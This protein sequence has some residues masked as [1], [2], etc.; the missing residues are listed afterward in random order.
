MHCS[1]VNLYL[2]LRGISLGKQALHERAAT[3]NVVNQTLRLTNEL[4]ATLLITL[5]NS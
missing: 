4:N 3:R 1:P 5:H 2:R